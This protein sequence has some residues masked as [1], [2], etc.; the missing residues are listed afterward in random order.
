MDKKNL[1][2]YID[3][4]LLKPETAIVDIKKLCDEAIEHGFASVCVNPCYVTSVKEFLKESDVKVCTVVGFPLGATTSEV[5]AFEAAQAIENGANEID[6]VINIGA[7][8]EERYDYVESD[9]KSVAE[10]CKG[11]AL[12]KVIIET[13]VLDDEQKTRACEL[14]KSAGA[15]YVKTSTGF[16]TSGAKVSDILLMRNTVGRDMGVKA[17]GGIRDLETALKMI[18]AGA[19]RIGT[20]ASVKIINEMDK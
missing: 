15:D 9:I 6:M 12:L 19:S 4:T 16:S 11:K 8:K 10:K 3:H 2:S 20:S 17:S 1:A 18:E 13:C 14:A 7:L 5:K